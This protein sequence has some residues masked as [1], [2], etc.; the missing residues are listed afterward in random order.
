MLPATTPLSIAANSAF[1]LNGENQQVA[2]LSNYS[3]TRAGSLINS[4]TALASILTLSSS[5]GS[6]SFSGVIAGGGTLGTVS[7]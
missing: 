2:S 6:T 3:A 5:G 4:N 1:D 7:L